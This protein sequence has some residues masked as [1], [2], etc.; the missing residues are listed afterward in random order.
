MTKT[1]EQV[2]VE[3]TAKLTALLKEYNA[4][5][6]MEE[7]GRCYYSDYQIVINIPGIYEDG[8]NDRNFCEIPCGRY[9]THDNIES[10]YPL[11]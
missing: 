1:A 2:K 8:P 9:I 5:I 3:F 7:V 4:K 10:A 6:E 11:V